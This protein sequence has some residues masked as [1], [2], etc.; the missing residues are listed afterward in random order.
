MSRV[1]ES[2]GRRTGL[3]GAATGVLAGGAAVGLA[4]ERFL[5]GRRRPDPELDV[6]LGSLHGVP[7]VVRAD[8]GVELYA[9]VED[10]PGGA[11]PRLTVVFVHGY[12]LNMDCWHFQRKAFRDAVRQPE[13]GSHH[14]SDV[15]LVFYDQRSHGRSGRSAPENCRIAQLG[16]DL[17]TMLD[18]LVPNGPIVL[19][20]H[21]MGGMSIMAA[22]GQKPDL[23]AERV[24]GVGL[25]GTAAG[26]MGQVTLGAPGPV[27]RL[28]HMCVPSFIAALSKAPD[29]VE[30]G[31]KAGSDIGYL[32][33]KRYSF[34]SNVPAS[35]VEFQA[36]MLSATPIEVVSDFF[37]AFAELD[38]YDSLAVVQRC[39]TLVMAGA[40]DVIVP[41]ERGRDLARRM[42]L[43]QYDEL[44]RCGHMVILEYPDVVNERLFGLV[45]RAVAAVE[46]EP[47][48]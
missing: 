19:I 25:L 27:G 30:H 34:G 48:R 43:A 6:P 42:P 39:E 1:W 35:R 22:A 44:A 18:E 10:P 21:S 36:E 2:A 3:V 17:I 15:R 12:A 7:A 14:A 23:F 38:E 31:R 47:V 45:E 29:L 16:A 24:I 26:D 46:R 33:T 8:D 41:V 37:P 5:I 4:V 11:E 40:D 20:G 9:E 32:M 13:D 28:V